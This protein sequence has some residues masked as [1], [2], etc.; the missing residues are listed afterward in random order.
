MTIPLQVSFQE[1]PSSA[2]V[3]TRIEERVEKLERFHDRITGC[4]V[5]ISTPHRHQR[6]GN[7]FDVRVD[8]SLPGRELVVHRDT[9]GAQDHDDI[10]IA[11]RDAFDAMQR[12]L[13]DHVEKTR[14]PRQNT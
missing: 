10:Y 7:H 4:R 13:L 5:V 14:D 1:L 3:K 11:V 6:K 9:A 12:Q 8:L 2:A